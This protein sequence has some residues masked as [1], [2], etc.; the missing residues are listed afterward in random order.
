[1]R[2][3]LLLW[4]L[5]AVGVFALGQL[6][7]QRLKSNFKAT[8]VPQRMTSVARQVG[9]AAPRPLAP[10]SVAPTVRESQP[11]MNIVPPRAVIASA[12]MDSRLPE[13][14]AFATWADSYIHTAE[15][16]RAQLVSQGVE[17]ARERRTA[18]AQLIRSDPEQ[19]LAAAVPLS[20]RAQLPDAIIDLL[21][22]RVAGHGEL[23]LNAV[24]PAPGQV[25]TEP[26]FRSALIDG[27]EYHAYTYGHRAV[28]ATLPD[29][30]INGI[31]ISNA[32][33]V[34]DS[35]LRML[36]PGEGANGRPVET[37]C[38]V[39]GRVTPVNAETLSDLKEPTAVEVNGRVQVLCSAGHVAVYESRLSAAEHPNEI[40]EADGAPGSSGMSGRP[41][42]A[43][44]HGTKSI[45]III[46]DFSDMPGT[47]TNPSDLQ[48][49]TENYAVNRINN[50][51]G[52]RDYYIQSSFSQTSLLIAP[53]VAGDSPDVTGVLR[54]PATASSYATSGNNSLLHSDAR[55]LAQAA[56]FAV[57][58]YDRVGV[59]FANLGNLPGSQI[60]YAGLANVI[61]SS[62][63]I[64][65][66]YDF[67]V[68][69][70][71]LGHT[72][73]LRHANLWQVNDG[74]PVSP[75]GSSIEYADI[76]DVMGSGLTFANQFN[77]LSKSI[78]QWTPDT[79]V[80]VITNG[81]TYRVFR[82]DDPAAKLTN[83]LALKI[84]RDSVRDYWIGYR[85]ATTSTSLDNGAYVLWGYNVNQASDL[86]DMTTPGSDVNDAGLPMNTTFND[87]AVGITLRPVAQG[88][89]GADEYLDVQVTF[90]PR[91]QWARTSVYADEG[92]GTA[93]L[94]LN[95]SYNSSG[96]VTVHYA[97]T[98][99]T[100]VSTSDYGAQN[101]NITWSNGDM[102]P[103]TI[104]ITLTNDG[105]AEGTENFGV[106][107]SN[108][109][110]GLIVDTN[111]AT[112]Y[113]TEPGTFD[114]EF[115]PTF[116]NNS[117]ERVLALPDGK[118]I[119][120]GWFSQV[121]DF[122]LNLYSKT[123][124]VQLLPNGNVDTN[125]LVNGGL[126]A[127][128]GPHVEDIAR[129]PDGKLV[130]VGNFTNVNGTARNYVARLNVDGTLDASFNPGSGA[131][132]P[133]H[134]VV[135]QPDGKILIGGEFITFNG[136]AREYV[137]RLNADGSLDTS[138][139]GPDFGQ[140]G[141]W[142]VETLALQP[143][144]KLFIG[145]VFFFSGGN[146]KGGIC[147]VTTNGT[148]DA[149]FSGVVQGA[150]QLGN[151]TTL[152][153]IER[154]AV[155]LDG[156]I[157]IAGQFSAYNNTARSA[158]ARLTSTGA[159]DVSFAPT[160]DSSSCAALSIQPDGKILLG[161]SF[162]TVNGA[163][164]QN[165][166]RLLT[167][168]N[169]DST[170]AA[171]SGP[172]GDVLDFALQPDGRVLFGGDYANFQGHNGP[173][174]RFF[175]GLS[176]APGSIQ[177]NAD[178]YVGVEGTNATLSATRVGGSSG[179]LS[180]NFATV[181][182]TAST[183]DFTTTAGTL[184]W[185][186]GDAATKIVTVPIVADGVAEGVESLIVNLGAPRM[187]SAPLGALQQA[188]INLYTGFGAW[189][190]TNFTP[191]E[192][193]NPLISGPDADPD[194][195][196]LKNAVE[197]ALGLSPKVA[198]S[199]GRPFGALMNVTGTNYL[200]ITFRRRVPVFD[201]QYLP[202]TT[203]ALNKTWNTDAVQVGAP[204]NNGDGTETV[205]Y[206]D[207][208]PARPP[209]NQRFMKLEVQRTP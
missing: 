10:T 14:S 130:I 19:A 168:G 6:L 152:M 192:L 146:F 87:S 164:A 155:Q 68:V 46:V 91:I 22:Q 52:V 37:V 62:F 109:T 72:Y 55:A 78:L 83:A 153:P 49:I 25:V 154:I 20:V 104:T 169:S 61:G 161:G 67:S 80:T 177:W 38:P 51:N 188:T 58:S 23:S 185:A 194:N 11:R 65:G 171:S 73:G 127:E 193:A 189:Q 74:N 204:V 4:S 113:I 98:N 208:V 60:T 116:I 150:H 196:G 21:E 81:G 111:I 182:G 132:D 175:S 45:L 187:N 135:V 141:G 15:A 82:F 140:S 137:A 13:L 17:L 142:S 63:W 35:P 202:R 28:L 121:Q 105:V 76:Y 148:L 100:A 181:P 57:N 199:N 126:S 70:H 145:G 89:S 195:D 3:R 139:V 144:R 156:S 99:G 112:V 27:H 167:N 7:S 138:F 172:T 123:G 106:V 97:T 197:Y 69:A 149:T 71:E 66:Y 30:S 128:S 53:T 36:E 59:V 48:T 129:Q 147:R 96:T 173:L 131:D 8:Y 2:S 40:N 39:S 92:G 198:N 122:Q 180:V 33:A 184:S 124:I 125:F 79:S 12:W 93:T 134:A 160:T 75:A 1:M 44:T 16:D 203:N 103:K 18:L 190:L 163:A 107:L 56:G 54:M 88:G 143:D 94:T 5:L 179:A 43:W 158:V 209:A 201:L 115:K 86:L 151:P 178:V 133:V 26:L 108:P 117:V 136:T 157:L 42:F 191:S 84:V 114:P 64:N 120:A 32:L 102:V 9:L 47:P 95:R 170:F 50:A 90:Q 110:G 174:W 186:D 24:T 162:T 41:T 183:N 206:R 205:T 77:H 159:L 31:A 34:S 166:V 119:A 29:A 85:R 176:G 207:S 118:V 200:T 101:G 165:M